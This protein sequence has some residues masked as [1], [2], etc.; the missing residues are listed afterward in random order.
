MCGLSRRQS[1]KGC[2]I[3]GGFPGPAFTGL[4]VL[5]FDI[6]ESVGAA[7]V[8]ISRRDHPIVALPKGLANTEWMKLPESTSSE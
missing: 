7:T 1:R 2:W 4:L 6:L 8:E 5:P 3:V